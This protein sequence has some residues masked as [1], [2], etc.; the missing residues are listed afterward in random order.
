MLKVQVQFHLDESV[1]YGFSVF[2]NGMVNHE[3][4]AI[5]TAMLNY[6]IAKTIYLTFFDEQ[7]LV[8]ANIDFKLGEVNMIQKDFDSAVKSFANTYKLR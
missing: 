7:H 2:L 8:I 6:A 4:L 3:A 1:A 5:S